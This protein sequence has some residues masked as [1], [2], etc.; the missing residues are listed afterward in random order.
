MLCCKTPSGKDLS[1]P[2]STLFCGKC[3]L[4]AMEGKSI[5]FIPSST[6]QKLQ[7]SDFVIFLAGKQIWRW[8]RPSAFSW[9]SRYSGIL[10]EQLTWKLY[11][12]FIGTLLPLWGKPH[13]R[14]TAMTGATSQFVR[15]C[16]LQGARWLMVFLHVHFL[17]GFLTSDH[18]R[19][20]WWPWRYF[21]AALWKVGGQV[22]AIDAWTPSQISPSKFKASHQT[23][24][25]KYLA[26]VT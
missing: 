4:A 14:W 18:W 5:L 15:G 1:V 20:W 8:K 25:I 7:R 17:C 10:W 9:N 2:L 23:C 16:F 11:Q 6:F 24:T 26:N 3:L 19:W 12:H 22:M 13:W 21:S